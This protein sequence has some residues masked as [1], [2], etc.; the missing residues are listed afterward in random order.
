[1]LR[2]QTGGKT[3]RLNI[4]DGIGL[5]DN[6]ALDPRFWASGATTNLETTLQLPA[7]LAI[8]RYDVLLHLFDPEPGLTNRPEY[9]IRLANQG[10]WE[11]QTGM[12]KLRLL[13]IK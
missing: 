8:G 13:E 4:T 10:V 12:N 2:A 1:V 9:A 6:R 7:D 11:A 5:P 3:Y